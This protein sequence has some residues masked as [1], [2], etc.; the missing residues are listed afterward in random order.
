MLMA[1]MLDFSLLKDDVVLCDVLIFQYNN[2]ID[3]K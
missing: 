1:M 2:K 3:N